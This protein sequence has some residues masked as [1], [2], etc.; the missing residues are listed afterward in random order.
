M[1][2]FAWWIRDILKADEMTIFVQINT[3]FIFIY[4][5]KHT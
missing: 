1:K 5:D 2:K 4:V 3:R